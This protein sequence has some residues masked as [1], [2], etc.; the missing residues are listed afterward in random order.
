MIDFTSIQQMLDDSR[1]AGLP[2]WENIQLS[3]CQRQDITPEAS[4]TRMS[5]MPKTAPTAAW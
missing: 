2:L 3:D 5:A 4:W 1:Q